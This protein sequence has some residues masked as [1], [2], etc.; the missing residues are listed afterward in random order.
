MVQN[1][2]NH[3]ENAAGQQ[4]KVNGIQDKFILLSELYKMYAT[5]N[6]PTDLLSWS[7]H[8]FNQL[9]LLNR[10]GYWTGGYNSTKKKT[11]EK[12]TKATQSELFYAAEIYQTAEVNF[13]SIFFLK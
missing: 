9:S 10:S 1:A 3:Q 11:I 2:E 12:K 6:H 4:P 5:E 13:Q 8:F 7:F